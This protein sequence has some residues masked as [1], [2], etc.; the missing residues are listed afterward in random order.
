MTAHLASQIGLRVIDD[1]NQ[2]NR[3][4]VFCGSTAI[5][6]VFRTDRRDPGM[7]Y[8]WTSIN[9]RY[10][11][12]PD[13]AECLIY[14]AEKAPGVIAEMEREAARRAEFDAKPAHVQAAI[15]DVDKAYRER[16]RQLHKVPLNEPDFAAADAAW[17]AAKA[18]LSDIDT[19]INPVAELAA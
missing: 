2:S 15:L 4:V 1:P 16:E 5:G 19:V 7:R 18:R 6:H 12:A 10:G 13:V 11:Y 14:L 8:E 9:G 3:Q 17:L